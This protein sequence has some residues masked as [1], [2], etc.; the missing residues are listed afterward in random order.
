MVLL[1][2]FK[3]CLLLNQMTLLDVTMSSTQLLME[4]LSQMQV[5]QN[6]S[7]YLAVSFKL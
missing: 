5:F 6:H 3:K 4:G 2:H 7:E 1:I